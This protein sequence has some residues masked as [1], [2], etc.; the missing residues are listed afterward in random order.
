M[1]A[2]T[3]LAPAAR[4]RASF[5]ALA[6][7]VFQ[8]LGDPDPVPPQAAES[9]QAHRHIALRV[10]AGRRA[11]QLLHARDERHHGSAI[12]ECRAERPPVAEE[13]ALHL[14]L[15]RLNGLA[16]SQGRYASYA[17]DAAGRVVLLQPFRIDG[18]APESL[19]AA[20]DATWPTD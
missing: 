20:I 14:E 13:E 5:I 17:L 9:L 15:L 4:S 1:M 16:R 18:C 12:L 10:R 2:A 19:V 6:R 8:L 11:V 3:A 7:R